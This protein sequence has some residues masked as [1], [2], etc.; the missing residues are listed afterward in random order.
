MLTCQNSRATFS[1]VYADKLWRGTASAYFLSVFPISAIIKVMDTS[2][3]DHIIQYALALAS[4]LDEWTAR[5]LGPIHFIKYVYLADLAYAK[6]KHESYTGV[7]WVFHHFG[8]WSNEVL[9]RLDVAL[10]AIGANK[11]TIPSNYDDS[12]FYRWCVTREGLADGLGKTLPISIFAE[13]NKSIKK[14]G[15]DTPSLLH[16]VYQTPPML[17]AAPGEELDLFVGIDEEKQKPE[18]AENDQAEIQEQL[19]NK[20]KRRRAQRVK[21]LKA[22]INQK[23]AERIKHKD[24]ARKACKQ[25]Y[26]EEF[27]RGVEWLDSLAGQPID[28]SEG[29][30][31][32]DPSMWKSDARSDRDVS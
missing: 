21:E 27:V 2:R 31:E 5:E 28:E 18:H 19:S 3:V 8:P 25:E 12:D 30:A 24:R 9:K 11:K 29:I 14:F 15:N 32:I 4:Q 6:N 7:N 1:G 22:Q 16:Y 13:L 26:D 10:D 20:E 17:T 23:I